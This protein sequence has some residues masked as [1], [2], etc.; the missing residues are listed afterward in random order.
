V[1]LVIDQRFSA[2]ER[3][4]DM[5]SDKS[6]DPLTQSNLCKLGSVMICG[7]LER[8]VEHLVIE[9]VGKRSIPQTSAFLKTFFKRGTNYDCEAI[10]QLLFRFDSNWG[11]LFEDFCGRN[12]EIKDGVSSCYAIRNSVAHGGTGSL[13]YTVLKQYYEAS[14]YVV[15]QLEHIFQR[16]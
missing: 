5:A 1:S 6:I 15:H 3:L 13:G 16:N 9:R 12:A 7:N 4:I 14:F 8:C 10:T 2:L 11:R